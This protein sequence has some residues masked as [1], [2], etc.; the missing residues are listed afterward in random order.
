MSPLVAGA[1]GLAIMILLL[2]SGMPLGVVMA[3]VGMAGFA[4]LV[5]GPAV[6]EMAMSSAYGSI[7]SY[8]L[9]VIPLFVLMGEIAFYSGISGSLYSVAN[10]WVGSVSGGLAMA[11]IWACAGFAAICGSSMASAATMATVSLPEMKRNRYSPAL[12]TGAVAAGGTLGVLIPPSTGFIIY[13][14]ITQTSIGKLFIS[15][16]A[17]GILLVILFSIT[18]FIQSRL[19]P[20]VG[21]PA[22][23]T[24]FKEKIYSLPQLVD[25]LILFILVMGGL[26]IGF[27][28]PT[29]AAAVGAFLT[30]LLSVVRRRLNWQG[31]VNSFVDTALTTGMIFFILIGAM[32]FNKF[33]AVSTIPAE[34]ASFISGLHV[35]HLVVLLLILIVYII[36]GCLLDTLAMILLTTPIFFP[37][38]M[39]LGYDPILFGV[40]VVIEIEM[41]SITP[42][43]GMNVFIVAGVAKDI[44]M[45]Q[46][47]K[48]IFPFFVMMA[49]AMAFIIAFPQ[50]ALFL[51]GFMKY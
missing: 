24:T 43:V 51:P 21:P 10:K 27:F 47:F 34:A 50:I 19:D 33:L 13:G 28:T 25:V 35:S 9:T 42:P 36:L 40:L 11:T 7:A 44:P 17:P 38:V 48:G 14:I 2:I 39:A 23:K 41:G 22:P 32:I 5:P 46:I 20:C 31:F 4:Y 37:V 12:A 8:D 49:V 1:I 15:G 16:I 45:Q 3:L 18:I 29:E 30:L 26:F 6:F